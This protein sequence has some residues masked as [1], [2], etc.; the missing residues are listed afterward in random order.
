MTW[1]L[2]DP[3]PALVVGGIA[4]AVL[5]VA[6]LRTG[7][8][9]L[10]AGAAAAL[11]ITGLCWLAERLVVTPR[12][13]VEGTIYAMAAAL[14]ANSADGLAPHIS[15]TRPQLISAVRAELRRFTVREA[16]VASSLDI[17]VRDEQPPATAR[18]TFFGLV[19]LK[20]GRGE[21]VHETFADRVSVDFRQEEGRWRMTGYTLRGGP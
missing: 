13:E 4:T 2:E 17:V 12:E 18:A 8:G 14:E 19:R 21:L 20:D 15:S 16:R 11:A 7:R 1:M 3:W 10:L 5:V 9:L 6:A